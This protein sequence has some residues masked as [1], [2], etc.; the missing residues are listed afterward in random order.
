MMKTYI[1]EILCA[2]LGSL[3]FSL[4]F[5]LRK[6][7]IFLASLG[8]GLTWLF[9]LFMVS[10]RMGNFTAYFWA[11]VFATLYAEMMARILKAP[12]TIFVI[13]AVVPLIPGGSLYYTMECLMQKNFSMVKENAVETALI[14]LAIA[15]GI[16]G[17]IIVLDIISLFARKQ[18]IGE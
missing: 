6:E 18:K 1:I 5:N 11:S 16:T 7:K 4:L 14:A 2:L 17:V 3:G 10:Q 13:P 9:Y 12:V 15:L 8:G